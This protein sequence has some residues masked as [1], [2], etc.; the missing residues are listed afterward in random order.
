[1]GEGFYQEA[2]RNSK[3]QRD[4]KSQ[5]HRHFGRYFDYFAAFSLP[6]RLIPLR[7]NQIWHLYMQGRDSCLFMERYPHTIFS[8]RS[9]P[10]SGGRHISVQSR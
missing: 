3:N 10:Q 9:Q 8:K 1:M 5:K 4:Q 7:R 2:V 6:G